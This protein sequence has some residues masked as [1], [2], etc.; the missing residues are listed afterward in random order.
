MICDVP[1]CNEHYGCT[2]R[3]KGI[4]LSPRVTPNRVRNP[5]PTPD[6]PPGHYANIVYD[7]RPDGSKMPVMNPDGTPV[8]HRQYQEQKRTID[9]HLREQRNLT[10]E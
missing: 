5:R 1:A 6:T 7:T 4:N 10:E 2:L 8:R 3:S 9:T